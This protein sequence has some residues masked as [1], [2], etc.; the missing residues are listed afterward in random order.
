MP[1]R[2]S[3]VR[4]FTWTSW[5]FETIANLLNTSAFAS[6]F[7]LQSSGLLGGHVRDRE[8]LRPAE[9]LRPVRVPDNL[10]LRHG[11]DHLP[12][13]VDVDPRR[14]ADESPRRLEIEFGI[15]R[16]E[17]VGNLVRMPAASSS[18]A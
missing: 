9:F 8:F 3:Y 4:P 16:D 14:L 13:R 11:V 10:H 2:K 7:P 12:V 18:A 5:S 1:K 15:P 17:N 6:S